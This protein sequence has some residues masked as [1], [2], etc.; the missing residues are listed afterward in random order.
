MQEKKKEVKAWTTLSSEIVHRNAFYSIHHDKYVLPNGNIGD[1]YIFDR[2]A[3]VFIVAVKEG[4]ILL[5]K[6]FR[7][8]MKKWSIEIP[9]GGK[10]EGDSLLKAA[11][12]ELM[13]EAG[14]VGR[15]KRI[16]KFVPYNGISREVC[17]VFLATELKFVGTDLE[18]SESIQRME[19]GVPEVFEM[20]ENGKITDGMTI[21]ALSI[22]RKYLVKELSR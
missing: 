15:L 14:Y 4:K 19:V 6:Q 11:K 2:E 21:S 22:A 20:I 1:Y 9:G 16:G 7:Y 5:G 8:P 17:V 18:D 13:Q 3:S 12:E 10:K